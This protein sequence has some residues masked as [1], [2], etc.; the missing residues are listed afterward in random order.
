MKGVRSGVERHRKR[1]LKA[2]CGRRE[3]TANVLKE[4]R[5]PRR[6]GRMGTSV[7]RTRLDGFD[8]RRRIRRRDAGNRRRVPRRVAR[9][10]LHAALREAL[11]LFFLFVR[12]RGGVAALGDGLHGR[13][14][15]VMTRHAT[16]LLM[17]MTSRPRLLRFM[18]A[19]YRIGGGLRSGRRRERR[20]GRRADSAG[21]SRVRER[22]CAEARRRAGR[23]AKHGDARD[24]DDDARDE[25]DDARDEDDDAR[26]DE[27]CPRRSTRGS[28]FSKRFE[29]R[30]RRRPG[31]ATRG[32]ASRAR[33]TSAARSPRGA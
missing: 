24:E 26:D 30:R 18:A 31:R 11:P 17:M 8:G 5:S 12:V 16:R 29:D 13:P 6:R 25:D 4:R 14:R 9:V 19:T 7:R 27:E 20:G 3:T 2:R 21:A 22:I 15:A 32:A 28:R 23:V 1:G 10:H 33:W